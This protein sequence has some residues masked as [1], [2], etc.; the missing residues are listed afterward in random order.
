LEAGSSESDGGGRR[1]SRESGVARG[2]ILIT[3]E[4]GETNPGDGT[5]KNSI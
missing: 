4:G 2:T 3:V 5:K 1:A